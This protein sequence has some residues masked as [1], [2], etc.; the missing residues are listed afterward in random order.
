MTGEVYYDPHL[1]MVRIQ[2]FIDPQFR[3]LVVDKNEKIT[4]L[5]VLG[6]TKEIWNTQ[7]VTGDCTVD[8]IGDILVDVQFWG[9]A[10]GVVTI[11]PNLPMKDRVV[12][13]LQSPE[14]AE[15]GISVDVGAD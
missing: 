6:G 9:V 10:D 5:S 8:W 12:A 1:Q 13:L 3:V 7:E 2:F 15:L 14:L 4:K 11:P